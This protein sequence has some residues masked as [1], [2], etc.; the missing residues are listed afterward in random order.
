MRRCRSTMM[1]GLFQEIH[2]NPGTVNHLPSFLLYQK[3]FFGSLLGATDRFDLTGE[4]IAFACKLRWKI[5]TFF[6]WW[7]RHLKVYQDSF[8]TQLQ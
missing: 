4:Q 1:T 7:K 2:H 3:R 5:E 8:F 6:A